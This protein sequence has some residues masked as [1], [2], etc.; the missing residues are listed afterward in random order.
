[1]TIII[2]KP[3]ARGRII[4]H[5]EL[6]KRLGRSEHIRSLLGSPQTGSALPLYRIS[7]ASASKAHP[8]KRARKVGWQYPLVGGEYPGLVLLFQKR[9]GLKYAG[10]IEGGMPKRLI[11]VAFVA[12]Q[13]L[14]NTDEIYE[15]RLLEMPWQR[16]VLLWMRG[17]RGTNWFYPISRARADWEA[18]RDLP[19]PSSHAKQTVQGLKKRARRAVPTPPLARQ[20]A[21][22]SW[23][24]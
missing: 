11:E 9:T 6:Q 10:I 7:T 1:M 20:R 22:G 14:R 24:I 17:S 12:E 23:R 4:V 21:R 2:Q 19:R 3:P 5:A 15:P 8:L 16:L 13:H 18:T